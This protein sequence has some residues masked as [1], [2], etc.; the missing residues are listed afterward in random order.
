MPVN[1]IRLFRLFGIT[2]SLHWS[3]L[4]V[5]AYQLSTGAQRYD[6][7]LFHVGEYLS[8]FGIV[9]LHEFGH[10]LA[11]RS[12]GGRAEQIMLWP[13]GGVAY[14]QPPPRPG[15]VLWSI[16]AGP[17]V[18]V[19][20]L[21]PLGYFWLHP[22]A[23]D[24]GRLLYTVAVINAF[25]LAFNLLP[26][27]PLDGGQILQALLWFV[28]GRARSLTVSSGIGLVGA[29]GLGGLALKTQDWWLGF[30]AFFVASRSWAGWK[31]AQQLSRAGRQDDHPRGFAVLVPRRPGYACPAC[32]T[33][34]PVGPHWACPACHA[35]V[36]KFADPFGCPAC[37]H[38]DQMIP[39]PDC[40]TRHLYIAWRRPVP[41]L[42]GELMDG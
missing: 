35:R 4:L 11:C 40:G 41:L 22:L 9:L 23:G 42:Q 17:L 10:A 38:A 36:D 26:I 30:L 19:A 29:V 6:S 13:L 5:A 31:H 12:V 8:L 15:A 28:I 25:L 33:A 24:V 34:P 32:A 2:V 27:Y 16:A 18:N 20:L 14:V 3:W 37:G 1:G 21:V 39:C 7:Q